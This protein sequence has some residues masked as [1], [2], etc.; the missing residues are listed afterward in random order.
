MK[1]KISLFCGGR[2]SSSIIKYLSTKKNIELSLLINAYDDGKSTGVLR[3]EIP[4][5]L[6]PSDFRKNFSYLINYFSEE[7]RYLKKIFEF[8]ITKNINA[9]KLYEILDKAL[10]NND[11]NSNYIPREIKNIDNKIKKKIIKYTIISTK[12]LLN[13]NLNLNDF[14]FGNLVFSGI[15]L[16]TNQN[17]N[18]TIKKFSQFINSNVKII[19]I[20][21]NSDKWLI[22][23]N[24]QNRII[25][26]EEELVN[27][28][29]KI[30]IKKLF[31]LDKNDKD[32]FIKNFNKISNNN[33]LIFLRNKNSIPKINPEAKKIILNSDYIIYGPGTQYSSLFPSYL[34]AN[35][36][37]KKSNAKKIMVMNLEKDNDIFSLKTKNILSEAISYLN[38]NN[39]PSQVINQ[40]LIDNDCNF[41]NLKNTYKRIKIEK[42]ELKNNLNKKIHS[43]KK[44]FDKIFFKEKNKK[45]LI[46]INL[47][48]KNLST[49]DYIDQIFN[50]N[51]K[52]VC[53]QFYIIINNGFEKKNLKIPNIKYTNIK[54][55]FPEMKIYNSWFKKKEFD[56]LVTISGDGFYDLSQI[57]DQIKLSRE[58]NCGLVI[59]SRNQSRSQHFENI[60]K[61]YGQNKI[62]Y[63]LSKFSE[64]FFIIIYFLKLKY[65]LLDPN[66]GYRIYF[67]ENINN[68]TN[69]KYPSSILKSFSI[70]KTEIFELPVNYYV[71]RN[72]S[73][74]ILRFK[75][76]LINI[77]GLFFD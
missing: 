24:K 10:S 13:S 51:W 11:F 65:F 22:S 3:K 41:N 61:I 72:I 74:K 69:F 27:Y 1:K 46:F 71:K 19:N 31:L 2:G 60:E 43:G 58:S 7:Q 9:K 63:I 59:G 18:L 77:K 6:G 17:F 8:R 26:N 15:F 44:I 4:N 39:K 45:L 56:Y 21:N 35:K 42:L 40:V 73:E 70:Y 12:Y 32:F 49:N 57:S 20:S 36:Y 14:S 48:K 5:L 28:K 23:I 68:T 62:L 66:S 25:K 52:S 75:Q 50:Q 55:E 34:I 38:S 67:R 47:N 16:S 37:I 76:A 30:P 29:Q 54:S 33:K 53:D 64:F